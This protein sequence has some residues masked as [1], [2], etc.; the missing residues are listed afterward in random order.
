MTMPPKLLIVFFH[1][2]LQLQEFLFVKFKVENETIRLITLQTIDF[3]AHG[4]RLLVDCA[5]D[6][7]ILH[8]F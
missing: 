1:I 2:V 7:V 8:H 4:A 5:R 3:M 6:S